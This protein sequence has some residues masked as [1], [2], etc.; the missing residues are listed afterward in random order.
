VRGFINTRRLQDGVELLQQPGDLAAWLHGRGLLAP[1]AAVSGDD[2]DIAV[3]M[4]ESLRD[5]VGANAGRAVPAASSGRLDAI[6][7]ACG[8]RPRF[9][10]GGGMSLAPEVDGVAGALGRL[11]G[12][13]VVS[14]AGERWVR[15]KTCRNTNCRW[16][17]YDTTRN[18]SAVW[19]DMAV[20]GSREKSRRY[21]NRHR[22]GSG[23]AGA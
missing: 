3:A 20:C 22:T 6:A 11:L 4:R 7:A 10:P 23:T 13:V 18:R 2:L 5:L 17:F 21:Y 9:E 12:I 19:C 16:A 1:G 14:V 15:L 8:L